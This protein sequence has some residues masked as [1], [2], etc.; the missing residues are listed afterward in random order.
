MRSWDFKKQPCLLHHFISA[1]IWHQCGCQSAWRG[2]HCLVIFK[3]V[4]VV[5]QVI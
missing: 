3:F 5:V 1:N 4:D 2:K